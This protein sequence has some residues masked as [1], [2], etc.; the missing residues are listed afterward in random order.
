MQCPKCNIE[1]D[2]IRKLDVIVDTCSKCGGVWLDKGEI[3]A[4]KQAWSEF[5]SASIEQSEYSHHKHIGHDQQHGNHDKHY[6]HNHGNE[7]LDKFGKLYDKY[8]DK[9][10]HGHKKKKKKSILDILDVFG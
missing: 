1:M 2:E 3:D 6:D 9:H 8:S 7:Y 10:G 4:L 5:S